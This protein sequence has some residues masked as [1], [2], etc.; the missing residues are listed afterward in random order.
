MLEKIK[1]YVPLNF[2]LM[3]NPVNWVIITLMVLLAG[4][5]LAFIVKHTVISSEGQK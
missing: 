5:G 2:E 3:R 1:A 4:I